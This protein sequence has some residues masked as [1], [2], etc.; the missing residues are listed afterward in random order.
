MNVRSYGSRRQGAFNIILPEARTYHSFDEFTDHVRQIAEHPAF[1]R[2]ESHIILFPET[3]FATE[4]GDSP[5]TETAALQRVLRAHPHITVAYSKWNSKPRDQQGR[6]WFNNLGYLVTADRVRAGAKLFEP[7][8]FP[9]LKPRPQFEDYEAY[10]KGM[11]KRN[12][13]RSKRVTAGKRNLPAI[14]VGGRNVT[15][16]I[17]ADSG[18]PPN[19][20]EALRLTPAHT[21]SINTAITTSLPPEPPTIVNDFSGGPGFIPDGNSPLHRPGTPEETRRFS[22]ALARHG[23]RIHVVKTTP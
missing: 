23:I 5:R 3:P 7:A 19:P 14:K 8:H 13:T 20:R 22:A 1:R 6:P 2:G 12:E 21:M 9:D 15:I 10:R 4:A 18:M 16:A 11:A 17:C